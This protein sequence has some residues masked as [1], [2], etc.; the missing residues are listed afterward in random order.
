MKGKVRSMTGFGS[1]AFEAEGARYRV[2]LKSVNHRNLNV[3]MHVPSDFSSSEAEVKRL[4]RERVTRGSVDV[5]VTMEDRTRAAAEISVD[6]E[7]AAAM[8]RA[9]DTLA[10]ALNCSPVG[11]ESVLRHGDFVS[12]SQTRCDPEALGSALIEGI[13]AAVERLD[14]SRVTEGAELARDLITRLSKLER[15]VGEIEA[16]S[17]ELFK[18]YEAK[19]R[20]R[21]SE[22]MNALQKPI[23]EAKIASE[24]VLFSDRCDVTE[25]T[26]RARAH[27]RAFQALLDGTLPEGE[28]LMGKRCEFLTQ[29]LGREFN[30][31]GS[32]CRDSAMSANVVTAKVELERIREQVHNIA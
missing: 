21:L 1:A 14:E 5:S 23:D 13:E 12:F 7:G 22:A 6:T 25:E 15:L 8:K 26:V 10:D 19:L 29:E 27:I 32:K 2:E 3:R 18:A 24:L 30:T 4:L 16:A 17:P 28:Q 31:I 20:Q 11:L 9:L